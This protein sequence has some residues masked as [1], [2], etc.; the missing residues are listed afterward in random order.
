MSPNSKGEVFRGR[1][2]SLM[3]GRRHITLQVTGFREAKAVKLFRA[4]ICFSIHM[5]STERKGYKRTRRNGHAIG[6]CEWA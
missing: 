1:S 5:D 4:R 6:K 3:S 2:D